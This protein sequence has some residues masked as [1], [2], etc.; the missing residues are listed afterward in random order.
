MKVLKIVGEDN[1]GNLMD[2]HIINPQN[3]VVNKGVVSKPGTFQDAQ[4]KLIPVEEDR[5]FVRIGGQPLI[6]TEGVDDV[7]AKAEAL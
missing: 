3:V 7:I 5:T 4:G 6:S 1:E 2:F